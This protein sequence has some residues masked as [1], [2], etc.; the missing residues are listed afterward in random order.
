MFSGRSNNQMLK[1]IMDLKGKPS[2]GFIR[3]C[4]LKDQH[5]DESFSFKYRE[6]DK[7]TQR[8]KE[9]IL[10]TIPIIRDLSS[11]LQAVENENFDDSTDRRISH[12][13]D[14][15]DRMLLIDPNQRI[16][17]SEALRHAFIH[18]K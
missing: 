8:E 13:K 12:L 14:L 7:F 10:T 15:L 18:E 16:S 1:F 3:K 11:E 2:N 4:Q 17:I 6:F 9:T 5:F